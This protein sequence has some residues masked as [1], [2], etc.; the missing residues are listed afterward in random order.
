MLFCQ[1]IT[2]LGVLKLT[3]GI[4]DS[5]IPFIIWFPLATWGY[6]KLIKKDTAKKGGFR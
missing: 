6:G 2:K 5:I 3:H 1:M 4:V